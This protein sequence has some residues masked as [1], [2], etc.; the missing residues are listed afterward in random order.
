MLRTKYHN[1]PW[2]RDGEYDWRAS[3]Q[4]PSRV[5]P[6]ICIVSENKAKKRD[7]EL[8]VLIIFQ[9]TDFRSDVCDTSSENSTP[10]AFFIASAL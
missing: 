5:V 6:A 1:Q 7:S 10:L 2:H 4:E 9:K 3:I 8:Y